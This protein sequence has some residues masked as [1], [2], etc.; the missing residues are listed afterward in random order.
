MKNKQRRLRMT[1]K[2]LSEDGSFEGCLSPYNNVDDGGDL[3][4][5]GAYAKTLQENGNTIPMLWQHDQ[6]APIGQLELEERADGLYCKG[7]LELDI[8]EAKKAYILLKAKIVKGLS[9]GYD[10]I[11]AQIVDG[12]RRLKE[13]RLWEGSVVTFPM[14]TLALVTDVKSRGELKGDF[15]EEL[16]ERQISDA[17]YQIPSA[18]QSALWDNVFSG[19]LKRDEILAAA[20]MIIQQF[21]D[22]YM[23]FLPQYLDLC[24]ERY[25]MD[26]KA[27]PAKQRETKEGRRLSAS[28]KGSLEDCHGHIK[29]AIDIL[30]ALMAEEAGEGSEDDS[31]D[32]TSKAAAAAAR[33][34]E[35]ESLHSAAKSLES[36]RALL[37]QA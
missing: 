36:M 15:N 19:E 12:V 24:A 27:W 30:A 23:E 11:K 1:I 32:A 35:P 9:I 26:L 22:A 7:Q 21:R 10:A 28:T 25:G 33:K 16:S 13:I 8:P 4:E 17:W 18:L 14:N 29:S 20:E 37:A 34:S 2:S 31:E 3:V 5:P 6:K